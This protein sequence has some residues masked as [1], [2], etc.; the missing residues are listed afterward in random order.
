[1]EETVLKAL[2]PF[3]APSVP[4]T[5]SNVSVMVAPS[6][7]VPVM[8]A[9]PSPIPPAVAIVIYKALG[10]SGLV[11]PD[12]IVLVVVLK[13]VAARTAVAVPAATFL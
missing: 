8:I 2:P 12:M 4:S 7:L 6:T 10:T 13:V 9:E 3:V 11:I 1:M 5:I